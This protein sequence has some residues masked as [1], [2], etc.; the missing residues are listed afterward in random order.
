[1]YELF[2]ADGG[3]F[4]RCE[5]FDCLLDYL[6]ILMQSVEFAAR[7]QQSRQEFPGS[8]LPKGPLAYWGLRWCM[9]RKA[10]LKSAGVD[11]G[12][13]RHAIASGG[14][15]SSNLIKMR[16]AATSPIAGQL[17][18]SLPLQ[19]CQWST[20]FPLLHQ[21]H[22]Y[23]SR[24]LFPTRPKTRYPMPIRVSRLYSVGKNVASTSYFSDP[25]KQLL[26]LSY[27]SSSGMRENR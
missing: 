6:Q 27:I 13:P 3:A 10:G 23:S 8:E 5:S 16:T 18:R 22:P 11:A 14:A 15:V 26:T 17:V 7:R 24:S 25:R 4:Q 2:P 20:R 9:V 12:P 19:M 21:H 1:M